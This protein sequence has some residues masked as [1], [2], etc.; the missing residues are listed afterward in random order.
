MKPRGPWSAEETSRFLTET[1]VPL[2]IACNGTSGHP[3]MASLWF[4]AIDGALWC[5]MQRS[6]RVASLLA[7]DPR[8]AFEVSV[9]DPPYRGV[10]GSGLAIVH[11][12]RGEVVLRQLI[13]RYLGDFDSKL[14]RL[15]LARIETEV[16]VEI[17]PSKVFSWDYR[18]RMGD[19]A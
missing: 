16:A 15:L 4:V 13:A 3:V 1:R 5:A 8:C 2:R 7:R 9:E 19:A 14:S 17:T 12:D 10:R 11:A 18:E 6:A